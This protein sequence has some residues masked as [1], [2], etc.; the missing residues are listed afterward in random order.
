MQ[1]NREKSFIL[2]KKKKSPYLFDVNSVFFQIFIT[3]TYML[4]FTSLSKSGD[5]RVGQGNYIKRL[6]QRISP[7]SEKNYILNHSTP[8][9]YK[10]GY[11][12]M[13]ALPP[14][15]CFGNIREYFWLS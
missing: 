8:M 7:N 5:L 14:R 10:N 4:G 9:P 1:K 3:I 12:E 11:Q 13:K 2:L 6:P 15:E